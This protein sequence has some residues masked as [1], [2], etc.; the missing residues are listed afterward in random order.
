MGWVR[1]IC[2]LADQT[3][4]KKWQEKNVEIIM[5]WRG[6]KTLVTGAGGF[7]GSHLI[8]EL[9]SREASV[10]ALIHYNSRNDWGNI[11][12]LPK[13]VQE[14]LEIISGDI[15]DSFLT[16]KSLKAVRK[17]KHDNQK[18]VKTADCFKAI[19]PQL[20]GYSRAAMEVI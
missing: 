13:E 11:E 12:L 2:K 4:I 14:K 8:E 1:K 19:A 20:D 5:K 6:T 18:I 9:V 3:K 16:K 10:R 7:I 17:E 15:R